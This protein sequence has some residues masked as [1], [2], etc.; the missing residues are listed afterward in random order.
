MYNKCNTE[1]VFKFRRLKE[2]C[3]IAQFYI[4]QTH[5]LQNRT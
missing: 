1:T 5:T 3:K 4:F 2:F